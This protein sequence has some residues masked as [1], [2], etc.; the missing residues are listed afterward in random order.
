[1]KL[2]DPETQKP[3]EFEAAG[4]SPPGPAIPPQLAEELA[5]IIAEALVADYSAEVLETSAVPSSEAPPTT[6]L[7][8]IQ[9]IEETA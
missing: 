7:A 1:M 6:A 8:K 9:V 4:S 3:G 5:E 2:A